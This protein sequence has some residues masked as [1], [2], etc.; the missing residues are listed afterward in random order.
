MGGGGGGRR[1]K[2][3]GAMQPL[4]CTGRSADAFMASTMLRSSLD[5]LAESIKDSSKALTRFEQALMVDRT[6]NEGGA[7][8]ALEEE[9][10]E[11]EPEVEAHHGDDE[12][13]L[14]DGEEEDLADE[15]DPDQELGD[16]GY[17]DSGPPVR[18]GPDSTPCR[19]RSRYMSHGSK[20]SNKSGGKRRV[21]VGKPGKGKVVVIGAH[22]KGR[23]PRDPN[24]LRP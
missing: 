2:G 16:D 13:E 8:P 15:D 24:V 21:G 4:C 11:L 1:G 19:G 3:G 20:G 12:P 9:P 17:V 23:A 22:G 6:R 14:A 5:K 7:E 18:Y 10:W